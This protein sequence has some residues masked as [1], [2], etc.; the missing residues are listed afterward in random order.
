MDLIKLR[1][2][3]LTGIIVLLPLTITVYVLYFI[4]QLLDG[5]LSPIIESLLGFNIPGLGALLTI[6][7]VVLVGLVATNVLGR[8]F[9]SFLDQLFI[10]IP[11][12]KIIYGATKQI[13]D[14]FSIQPRNA[15]RRVALVEYPRRGI[16]SIVF[17]TSEGV[18]EV[19]EKTAQQVFSVFIPTTPNPTSGMLLLVPREEITFLEMCVED[20][21]KLIISGGVVNPKNSGNQQ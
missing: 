19:Q 7:F 18:G 17:V 16:Y 3:F 14:A 20:A 13:I 2:Y 11:M 8:K 1:K 4:F 9:I 10:R 5:L 15:L 12:V 6:V 21:L